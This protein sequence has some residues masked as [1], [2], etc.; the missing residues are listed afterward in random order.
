MASDGARAGG[1]RMAESGHYTFEWKGAGDRSAFDSFHYIKGSKGD[2][3]RLTREKG[4]GQ[5][6]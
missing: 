4:G 5:V 1:R 2:N 6:P 3:P